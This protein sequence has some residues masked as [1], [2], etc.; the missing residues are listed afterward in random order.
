MAPNSM[1]PE[2]RRFSIRVPRPLWIGLAAVVVVVAWAGLNFGL[3]I[4]RQQAAKK[5]LEQR[6]AYIE[7]EYHGPEWLGERPFGIDGRDEEWERNRLRK[8]FY[9]VT[10]VRAGNYENV[11]GQS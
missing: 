1:P 9:D 5:A 10:F 7:S 3:P 11:G 6:G 2:P 4:Y 8:L